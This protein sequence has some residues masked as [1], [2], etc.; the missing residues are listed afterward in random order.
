[1]QINLYEMMKLIAAFAVA[2]T[3]LLLLSCG[4]QV[5]NASPSDFVDGVAKAL[6]NGGD[7]G[8]SAFEWTREPS[9]YSF[10]GQQPDAE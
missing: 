8:L 7:V 1:M 2:G 5:E 9:A 4:S 6:E 10:D 3:C